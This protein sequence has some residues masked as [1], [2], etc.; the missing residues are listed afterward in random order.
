MPAQVELEAQDGTIETQQ[1]EDSP[2]RMGFAELLRDPRIE[3]SR[4]EFAAETERRQKI[5]EASLWPSPDDFRAVA[6]KLMQQEFTRAPL[7]YWRGQWLRWEGTAWEEVD[8]RDITK[9]IWDRLEHAKYLRMPRKQTEAPELV[10]WKPNK[11]KVSNVVAAL[12]SAILVAA[13]VESPEWVTLDD[14][15]PIR[16]DPRGDAQGLVAFSNGLL[17]LSD[18]AL[19]DH[20]PQ[21]FN[22]YSLPFAYDRAAP[23]PRRW[24]ETLGQWFPGDPEA[25]QLVQEWFG[26]VVSGRTDLQK[27]L[28]VQGVPRSGKGTMER[29]LEKLVGTKNVVSLTASNLSDEYGLDGAIGKALIVFPDVH[30]AANAKGASEAMKKI[31]GE[32]S[33]H[34]NRKFKSH[35]DGRLPGRLMFMSNFAPKFPDASKATV[36]RLLALQMTRSFLGAEDVALGRRL[37]SELPGILNW[38]LEGLDH[39]TRRGR[40][41][42][43]A[44]GLDLLSAADENASPLGVFV[45]DCCEVGPNETAGVSEVYSAW[46]VWCDANG[47]RPGNA[48]TF[49]QNLK[50]HM[51]DLYPDAAFEKT[52]PRA[53]DGSRPWR[54]AGLSV[55]KPPGVK[56]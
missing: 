34:I 56:S 2:E 12:D 41:V 50:G 14:G 37:E 46:K 53:E 18:R 8:E 7:H 24:L 27:A 22:E 45:E 40:F 5:E 26:Y 25:V 3:E 1:R 10:K 20:S 55:R 31:I 48:Q 39:L 13:S 54:Y 19:L 33:M 36:R 11:H 21:Y 44:S 51:F 15:R 35:W 43:P 29:V 49:G 47:N 4:A 16:A 9:I 23:A 38:A 28:Y 52:R 32:D 30:F 6:R 17:R 42:Q